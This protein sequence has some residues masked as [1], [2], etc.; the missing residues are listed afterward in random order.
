MEFK[1]IYTLVVVVLLIYALYKEIV[2]PA[3]IFFLSAVALV[4]GKIITPQEL[5]QGLSNLQIIIIFLL[6]IVTAGI[7]S[8][9]GNQFFTTLFKPT[10]KPKQFLLR[11]MVFV[12]STSAFLNNT[13]IV[14]FMIPYVKDWAQKA[15]VPASKFLIPLS[16]ATVLGGM[17][18]VIGT[19]TNL[20]L[21]GL[22]QDY[23]LPLLEFQDF[24]Y[25]G[26]IVTIIGWIYF[27]FVGYRLL[28]ANTGKLDM[29]K[30]N[31]KEYIVETE[32]FQGSKIIG[33]SVK[34]AGLRN[35]SD[36]FLVEIVRG[37]KIISPV[38]PEEILE[39]GDLLF[40]SGN[41]EAIY[42]LIKE[43]NG[44]GVHKA[45]LES[46]RF[47]FLE[48]VVPA[49]SD[50]IGVKIKNSDFRKKYDASI[51]ALHRDG[52]R[53]SGKVGETELQ[54]GDFLLLVTDADHE[55][56]L[57][58][59]NLFFL[60]VPKSIEAAKPA[61]F[62]YLGFLSFAVL[63][64]GVVNV[65]PLFFASLLVLCGF[66]FLKVIGRNEIREELDLGLLMVLVCSL[67][68]GVALEKSGTAAMIAGWLIQAGNVLGPVAALAALFLVTLILTQ[69]ITNAAAVAIVFPV[70]MAMSSQL[71][72]SP[73]PF[74]AA[75]AFAASGCF[76]TP[77]GYQTN[78][79]VYG[80]GGYT[81]K[82]FLK[83]GGPLTVLYIV[84]CITFISYFY[85]LA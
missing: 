13:P 82:D 16:F 15:G 56:A 73:T 49:N 71:G 37:D 48:A 26:V 72:L 34:D 10:L 12:S 77:I 38:A 66:V 44:L 7:R 6:V 28:P 17:M 36:L 57:N 30:G 45:T 22:I 50:L 68:V 83:V 18:T 52:K 78:L 32:I 80:P 60:S 27:Y 43:D 47:T 64:L 62:R 19:S 85:N 4:L 2:S 35:L 65:I 81:F 21:Q 8:L 31:L 33:K 75:I 74:F 40:F 46:G 5:L 1:Q 39:K 42:N 3:I 24:F 23:N 76:L 84:T 41:T 58:S 61:W 29:V 70:A 51:V 69:L 20:V 55:K 54:G 53:V 25:L 63:L 9:V 59:P 11:M 79:M 14:A 67:A